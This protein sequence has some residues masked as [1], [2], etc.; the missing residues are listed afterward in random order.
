M[1]LT[2]CRKVEKL[3]FIEYPDFKLGFTTQNFIG[4][5]PVTS[6]N[7]IKLIDYASSNGFCWIELRD[8]DATLTLDECKQI[9]NH[10]KEKKIEIA[11][12]IQSGL[13]NEDFWDVFMRGVNNAAL[14]NDNGPCT[15]RT[16]ACGEEF[17]LDLNKKGWTQEELFRIITNANKAA[18]IASEKGVQLVLENGIEAVFSKDS[19]Y[20]GIEDLFL[21]I[22]TID[23][24]FD[25]ANPFSVS[26][27]HSDPSKVKEFL[28]TNCYRL[29]YIHLK[30]SH[31]GHAQPFLTANP[32]PFSD[33]FE[34][35]HNYG[36]NYIA[37]ELSTVFNENEVYQNHDKSILF[38]KE[39]GFI[40]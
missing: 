8:P 32:L 2:N 4:S 39:K 14:F 35:L 12:A 31:D 19:L 36:I 38:L 22:N 10:A 23:L 11:Y 33:I 25:T 15:L 28:Q 5:I 3:Q 24:Q 34:I 37:V 7:V 20:F 13:L 26:R 16:S 18:Q 17:S 21:Q 1:L 29:A 30:S 6:K 27:V 40:F 9:A